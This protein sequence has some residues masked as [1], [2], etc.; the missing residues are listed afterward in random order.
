[1]LRTHVNST[2]FELIDAFNFEKHP[3]DIISSFFCQ[4]SEVC[5]KLIHYFE[6]LY[7]SLVN[8]FVLF[9]I[10]LMGFCKKD[11]SCLGEHSNPIFIRRDMIYPYV[12]DHVNCYN[13]R[14]N[15]KV[16]MTITIFLLKK[17]PSICSCKCFSLY[18]YGIHMQIAL[19]VLFHLITITPMQ[20]VQENQI[21][22]F[23]QFCFSKNIF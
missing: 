21:S 18:R 20:L 23:Y 22:I 12:V 14:I 17:N 13:I 1:M 5:V 2:T 8:L 9:N 15:W 16:L 6:M 7:V 4:K 11:S 10:F 3:K 19:V